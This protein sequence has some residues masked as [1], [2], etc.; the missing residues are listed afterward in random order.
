MAAFKK[1][2]S[3]ASVIFVSTK[4]RSKNWDLLPD[5]AKKGLDSKLAGRLIPKV[6]ITD[7]EAENYL[8]SVKYEEWKEESKAMRR[9]R[10]KLKE[11]KSQKS[12][13]GEKSTSESQKYHVWV[14]FKGRKIEAQFVK[15]GDEDV[16][17]KLRSGKTVNYKLEKLN[18]DSQKLAKSLTESVE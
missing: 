5:S 17:L 1:L 12:M 16:V 2:R 9:V 13:I 14:N 3:V 10:G 15:G 18:A 8:L 11:V 7:S 6:A 4:D